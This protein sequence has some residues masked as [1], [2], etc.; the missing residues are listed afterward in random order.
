MTKR[1]ERV[2]DFF[3]RHAAGYSQSDSHRAGRDLARLIELLRPAPKHR[4]LDVATGV[5]HTA[6]GLAPL[7]AEVVGLDM[8][9]A[10]RV[11]FERNVA[12]AGLSNCR[13]VDGEADDLP[14]PDESFDLVTCRRAFHH[15]PAPERAIG[16][17]SRVLRPGGRIGV[18]DMVAPDDPAAAALFNEIERARDD[19][20]ARAL[21]APE[22]RSLVESKGLVVEALLV[23]PDRIPW[24]TW[25]R[26]V[27]PGGPEE[28][29]AREIAKGADPEIRRQVVDDDG[30]HYLKGRIVLVCSG[31]A[32]R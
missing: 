32:E 25:I 17:M 21:S 23:V 26:P 7:V 10:M 13:F 4:C 20:H 18:V 27:E 11:E 9:P 2:R 12:E 24:E 30:A 3:T 5:G 6:L 1:E 31:V 29:R 15:F 14:Y 16:E 28:H 22:W 8:T 19:S